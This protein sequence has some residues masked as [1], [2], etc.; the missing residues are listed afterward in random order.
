MTFSTRKYARVL[1]SYSNHCV[2]Y[3]TLPYVSTFGFCIRN[4]FFIKVSWQTKH[5]DDLHW[6]GSKRNFSFHARVREREMDAFDTAVVVLFY[7]D[8]FFIRKKFFNEIDRSSFNRR[9]Q[10]EWIFSRRFPMMDFRFQ[11]PQLHYHPNVHPKSKKKL[12]LVS[13]LPLSLTDRWFG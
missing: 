7:F 9:G 3:L 11:F 8:I 6:E 2:V 4:F 10:L 12:V 5:E 1:I 13:S